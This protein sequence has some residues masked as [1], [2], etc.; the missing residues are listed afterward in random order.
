MEVVAESWDHLMSL[1]YADS[2]DDG[3]RRHRSKFVFRGVTKRSYAL[4]PS[5]DRIGDHKDIAKVERLLLSDFHQYAR[6]DAAPGSS[7]WN[8]LAMAQ[9]Y[10]LPTRF[11]D[12]TFSPY[13]ALHFATDDLGPEAEIGDAAIW[14]VNYR[15]TNR[16]LP[17]VLKEKLGEYRK[18]VFSVETLD[19]VVQ[20]LKEL[21][22]LSREPF[23]IF[24]EPP[25]LDERIVN[26]A[27]LFS[28]TSR[29]E[30][31]DRSLPATQS[32]DQILKEEAGNRHDE[33]SVLYRRIEIP[34][35]LRWEIRDKLDQ[36]NINERVMFPGLDGLCQWLR[37]HYTRRPLPGKIDKL[38]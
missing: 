1:L 25:S 12:W 37:R 35:S 38:S 32:L 19:S 18:Q 13:V 3:L 6:S 10:G 7:E 4:I 16:T 33:A 9:H 28:I 29:P 36:A 34:A 15:E 20:S 21:D 30:F 24:L 31:Q 8:W 26:Q 23:V 5:L 14:C 2:W 27:A 17:V 22:R 11:L